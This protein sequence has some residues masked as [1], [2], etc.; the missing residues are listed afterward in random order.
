MTGTRHS[1]GA[2]SVR[3][4]V[5]L[6]VRA[7]SIHNSQ[8]W[9]W[10]YGPQGLEL[11]ADR[12]RQLP[13]IDPDGRGLLVSC[14]AALW[15]AQLSLT[16]QGWPAG[17]QR[18]P[19]PAR[20]DLLAR[21]HVGAWCPPEARSRNLV[22][23]AEGRRSE[24]RPFGPEP[25]SAEILDE[26]CR[27]VQTDAAYASLVRRPDDRLDLA[28]A[29]AWADSIEN[30]D[31]AYRAELARWVRPDAVSAG[32]GIPPS[33]VPHLPAGQVRHCDVPLRDFELGRDGGQPV[34][35]VDE[36]PG[37]LVLFTARDDPADR[38]LAGEVFAHL[39]VQ[40]QRMGLATNAA[41]QAVDL[42]G[43]RDRIR[44]LMDWPDHAQMIV[45]VG[46]PPAG[47]PAPP[48]PRRRVEDVLRIQPPAAAR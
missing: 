40:A 23:A 11:Y 46:W 47:D 38:L 25:V 17:V 42:P 34:T 10:E 12:T 3:A 31:P 15:L 28:V 29:M 2:E 18:F 20:P 32:V 26:L 6:A 7:P 43:V 9:R 1:V 39:S 41:T 22:V 44:V 27:L 4:A 45:R 16:A 8:P 37:W 33:A 36:R 24:R 48:T 14:G 35:A 5:A 30:A 21:I 13:S 19:D